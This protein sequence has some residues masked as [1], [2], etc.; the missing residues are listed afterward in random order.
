[1]K[2]IDGGCT[3][4]LW[5]S[6]VCRL[7][8]YVTFTHHL[9]PCSSMVRA[10][11]WASE[12]YRLY[13]YVTFTHHLSPCSSM[14]RTSHCI[15]GH[16]LYT[17]IVVFISSLIIAQSIKHHTEGY[18]YKFQPCISWTYNLYEQLAIKRGNKNAD[19]FQTKK[20]SQLKFGEVGVTDRG[21]FRKRSD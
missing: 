7:Y 21:V 17:H 14:V 19:K 10:S 11:H 13:T 12:G 8:T 3:T 1:M 6:E 9:S 4:N 16:M 2:T 15:H 18:I 20:R 5:S